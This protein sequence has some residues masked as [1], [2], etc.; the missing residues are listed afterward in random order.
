MELGRDRPEVRDVFYFPRLFE[1][2]SIAAGKSGNREV[3]QAN[4][5]RFLQL[6]GTA[7]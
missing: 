7:E 3:A 2:R 6:S 4:H 5:Q 1:L